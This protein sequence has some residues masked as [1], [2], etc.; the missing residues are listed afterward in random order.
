VVLNAVKLAAKKQFERRA[1]ITRI[2]NKYK[3]LGVQERRIAF[4]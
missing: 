4:A 3:A 2:L 1:L